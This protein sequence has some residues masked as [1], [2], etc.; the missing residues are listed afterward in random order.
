MSKEN[1][2]I[3]PTTYREPLLHVP[4]DDT[5]HLASEEGSV[6][7]MSSELSLAAQPS[8]SD[9]APTPASS[10]DAGVTLQ[11]ILEEAFSRG[12]AESKAAMAALFLKASALGLLQSPPTGTFMPGRMP[13]STDRSAPRFEGYGATE[14]LSQ[15]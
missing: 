2:N 5:T 12:N 6:L 13:L 4:D 3:Q 9:L 1:S 11:A 15:L 8:D 10:R 14:F 7:D